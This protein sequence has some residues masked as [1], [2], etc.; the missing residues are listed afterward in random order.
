MI[1]GYIRNG[2]IEDARTLFDEMPKRDVVSW[3]TMIAGYAKNGRVEYAQHFFDKM[4]LRDQFFMEFYN[5]RTWSAW[6]QQ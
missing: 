5:W 4:P 2:Q 3:T 1:A 6:E